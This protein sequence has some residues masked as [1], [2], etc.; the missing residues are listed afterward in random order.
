MN[1]NLFQLAIISVATCALASC[2]TIGGVGKDLQVLGSSME[3]AEHKR[4]FSRKKQ[5]ATDPS[6]DPAMINPA[7][8]NPTP[9]HQ[10]YPDYPVQ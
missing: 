7:L 5:P 10:G 6:I 1:K 4:P 2:G 8:L 9:S 3:K